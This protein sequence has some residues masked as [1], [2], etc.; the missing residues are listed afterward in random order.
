MATTQPHPLAEAMR[1]NARPRFL[2]AD[3]A[4]TG[5]N[6]AVAETGGFV[7]RTNEGNADIGSCRRSMT[8]MDRGSTWRAALT[9]CSWPGRRPPPTSRGSSS[10]ARKVL[11]R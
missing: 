8:P 2:K 9:A 3:A 10:A 7:V 1:N 5:A 6:F 4:M 11:G